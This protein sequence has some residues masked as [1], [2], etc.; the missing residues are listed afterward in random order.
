MNTRCI[1]PPEARWQ[2]DD[3]RRLYTTRWW[4]SRGEVRKADRLVQDYPGR[5][6]QGKRGQMRVRLFS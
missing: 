3:V 4:E 5:P 1:L 2:P 6:L